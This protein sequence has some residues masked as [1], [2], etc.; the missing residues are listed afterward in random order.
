MFSAI[1]KTNLMRSLNAL[2]FS[3]SV[4]L[5]YLEAA[6]KL[7]AAHVITSHLQDALS[8]SKKMSLE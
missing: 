8:L 5:Q 6:V 1:S 4:T 2:E 3:F 7:G